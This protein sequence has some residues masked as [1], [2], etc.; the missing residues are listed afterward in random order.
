MRLQVRTYLHFRSLTKQDLSTCDHSAVERP[1]VWSLLQGSGQTVDAAPCPL[2]ITT[3]PVGVNDVWIRVSRPGSEPVHAA[4]TGT[5]VCVLK[6]TLEGHRLSQLDRLI[7]RNLLHIHRV[8]L[9]SV[10]WGFHTRAQNDMKVITVCALVQNKGSLWR[11]KG[12]T[13]HSYVWGVDEIHVVWHSSLTEV[14][15][16]IF[17]AYVHDV[18]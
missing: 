10:I 6:Q 15:R 9:F 16:L 13:F 5:L 1:A 17:F 4:S 2:H 18:K 12:F 14:G 11:V 3:V 7:G 8:L